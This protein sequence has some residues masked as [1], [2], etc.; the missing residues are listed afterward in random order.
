MMDT[1][2][3]EF[4]QNLAGLNCILDGTQFENPK[5]CLQFDV[6]LDSSDD[7]LT[8]KRMNFPLQMMKMQ[9]QI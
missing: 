4:R 5:E 3:P 9:E 1:V 8:R 2:S 7:G 6:N